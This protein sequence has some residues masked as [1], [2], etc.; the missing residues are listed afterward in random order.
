MKK[1][2]TN[3]AAK[4]DTVNKS[5]VVDIADEDTPDQILFQRKPPAVDV[6]QKALQLGLERGAVG[7]AGRPEQCPEWVR[8]EYGEWP[9][10][11]VSAGPGSGEGYPA[12]CLHPENFPSE[13]CFPGKP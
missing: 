7:A 9:K 11:P 1:L 10:G 8:P 6:L 5:S 13:G 4:A 2:S 3:G 12:R